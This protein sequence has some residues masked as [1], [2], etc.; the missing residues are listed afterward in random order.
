MST[1]P[2]ST[3]VAYSA[4]STVDADEVLSVWKPDGA[5]TAD[6][7]PVLLWIAATAPQTAAT[8][9]ATLPVGQAVPYQA[10]A[11]GWAVV[12]VSVC[13][14]SSVEAGGGLFQPPGSARWIDGGF[15]NPWKS[16]AQAVGWAR[17]NAVA[18]SFDPD[19]VV[20]GGES[21]G[22]TLAAWAGLSEDWAQATG[23]GQFHGS[24]ST[25]PD[26]FV[27]LDAT[28]DFAA[29]LGTLSFLAFAEAA[30]DDVRATRLGFAAPA[31]LVAA[32]PLAV[33]FDTATYPNATGLNNSQPALL[34][35]QGANTG[36]DYASA[37][38]SMVASGLALAAVTHTFAVRAA[39][40]AGDYDAQAR[41]TTM[42]TVA[43][44]GGLLDETLAAA[45]WEREFGAQV[46]EWLAG[47]AQAQ[48][49]VEPV[50]ERIVDSIHAALRSIVKGADYFFTPRRV[51]REPEHW[52]EAS[53]L[54]AVSIL[55]EGWS[56]EGIARDTVGRVDRTLRLEVVGMVE[57]K[58]YPTRDARRLAHDLER[59]LYVDRARGGLA[60]DTIVTN[61]DFLYSDP[62]EG[63]LVGVRLFVD[64]LAR[65]DQSDILLPN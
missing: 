28:A 51:T 5:P 35:A 45:E 37:G 17:A 2:T 24:V 18:E 7:W 30:D 29:C 40:L 61:T 38:G 21:F 15:P 11:R 23:G 65:V 16:A 34:A 31:D 41:A 9:P 6:G 10:L 22:G 53:L 39:L 58:S 55:L 52:A 44:L 3:G 27:A 56:S 48:P 1:T 8:I 62:E 32:S 50:E 43:T 20:L 46:G 13:T 42:L 33:G 25:R 49:P 4:A 59:A 63:E 64:V 19:R 26:G 14:S 36:A 57:G 60:T 12:L 47:F 54:P